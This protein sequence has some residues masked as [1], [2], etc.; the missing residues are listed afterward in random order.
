[1]KKIL[2]L[3]CI[4]FFLITFLSFS[5]FAQKS[6]TDSLLLAL[7]R[8][9]DET[10]KVEL[11]NELTVF[12]RRSY[13]D[14]ALYFANI[15]ESM[16]LQQNHKKAL[17]ECYKNIGNI[18]NGKDNFE[19]ANKFYQ[20]S[21]LIC[22]ELGDSSGSATIYNNLGALNRNQGNFILS[23]EYYQRSLELR[24]ILGDKFKMGMTYNNIGNI[25]ALQSNFDLALDYYFKSLTIRKEFND[26]LGMSGCYNNIG[27]IYT[28][29]KDF[30]L[31]I[32]YFQE[33]QKIY[34][35]FEDKQGLAQCFKNIGMA[36]T[37][38]K[39]YH[40]AINY[41]KKSL[42][43]DEKLE[44]R[45]G[46][47]FALTN[48]AKVYN[49]NHSYLLARDFAEKSLNIAKATGSNFEK[50]DAY[51]QLSE[52][53]EGIGNY[54]QALEY[55]KLFLEAKDKLFSIEKTKELESIESKYQAANK[56]LQIANLEN[57]NKIKLVL[58]EKM[59]IRQLFSL[60][61]ILIFTTFIIELLLIRKKLKKKNLTI[62][63]QNEEIMAQKDELE[64]HRNHLEKLVKERTRDL[65]L[66]KVKAEESDRLKSS[67]LANMSHEIRTPMNAIMGFS[68][69]L[70]ED[71]PD[72]EL[73]KNLSNEISKNGFSLLNL[74]DNILDLAKIETNQLKIDLT[75]FNLHELLN[76]IYYTYY[77]LI[78]NNELKFILK[79]KKQFDVILYSDPIRIKQIFKNL[80]E[81]A[82][83]FTEKGLIEIG[84]SFREE[85]LSL[86]VKDTGIG[87]DEKQLQL[88]FA[89]F[90]KIENNKQKLYRGAGLGLSI[91]KQMTELLGGEIAVESEL[92]KGST[93]YINIPA[94]DFKQI[95]TDINGTSF[96]SL[97]YNWVNKTILIA[98]DDESNF[99][100]LK[101]L[102]SET[103]INII[104]AKTGIEA[105]E[106]FKEN[107]ID[108]ILMDIKM[109]KMDGLEA[110]REI[111][112]INPNIPIIAQTAFA[113]ENDKESSIKA[114]CSAYVQKPIHKHS[115]FNLIQKFL[116]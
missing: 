34:E 39:K 111:K 27:T 80:I 37:D 3:F 104:Q 94:K 31:A 74:I 116:T 101:K 83:K 22:K 26:L 85:K 76:E 20:K 42:E 10:T 11:L 64:K 18:Y 70:V 99:H 47:A 51:E 35:D 23:L 2:L 15:A 63:E 110:T 87:M 57:D 62:S 48:I 9:K 41:F 53:Y 29:K 115:F 90:S 92:D 6:K 7:N 69:L 78:K 68:N 30:E 56:Q 103:K 33:S 32:K 91:C 4:Q 45:I 46:Q 60:A 98:E 106:K 114:G 5:L 75:H 59:K 52:A 71:Q 12:L 73:R 1:M 44:D 96:F 14:S 107:K 54:K 50:K 24:K 100:Y 55:H 66:A 89:R 19:L 93:F 36:Y 113:M 58:L 49:R 8:T 40:L 61:L 38:L 84:Y 79:L 43:I 72:A 109:P 17:L 77:E 82:I 97:K 21:L 95:E 13:P 88:I 28:N 67:F 16:A 65:E 105:I 25:H 112:K 86:Y 108:L 102:F 81:N